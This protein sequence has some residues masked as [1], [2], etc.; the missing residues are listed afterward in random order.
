MREMAKYHRATL[1]LLGRELHSSEK[2]AA[3]V[4]Q[5]EERLGFRLPAS[6]RGWYEFDEALQVLDEHSNEDPAIP[7]RE[8][9]VVERQEHRFLP[10]R[11]ENQGVCTWAFALDGSDD[12]PVHVDVDSAGNEWRLHAPT[13]SAYVYACVWDHRE[14]LGR[15]ALVQAQNGKL[16]RAALERLRREFEP[17]I[18]TYGW[19]G[20]V[21]YRFVGKQAA[22]LIWDSDDQADWFIAGADSTSLEAAIKTVWDIDNVGGA[23]Y[24]CSEIGKVVLARL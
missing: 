19:P 6:V 1:S 22:L 23:L 13:F 16:S 9:H 12:P 2:T 10:I 15:P 14:I 7:L 21:Q 4:L 24:E 3:T 5:T 20:N 18:V 8:F 11:R 17:E